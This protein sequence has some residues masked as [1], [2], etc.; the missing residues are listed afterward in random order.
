MKIVV[1]I[2]NGVVQNVISDEAVDVTIVDYDTD[3]IEPDKLTMVDGQEALIYSELEPANVNPEQVE[4]IHSEI[5]HD[6]KKNIL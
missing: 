6:I 2:K 4:L 1:L 5:E 3:G